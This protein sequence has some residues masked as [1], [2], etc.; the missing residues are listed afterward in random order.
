MIEKG[1]DKNKQKLT[2]TD[3]HSVFYKIINS[4]SESIEEKRFRDYEV[5]KNIADQLN[6]KVVKVTKRMVETM[7][8]ELAH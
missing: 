7:E 6:G 8:M 5:A 1:V 4:T 3:V 2:L